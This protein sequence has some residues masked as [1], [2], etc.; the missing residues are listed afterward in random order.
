MV[1]PA[2]FRSVSVPVTSDAARLWRRDGNSKISRSP[3]RL[4]GRESPPRGLRTFGSRMALADL[5]QGLS[6]LQQRRRRQRF[7]DGPDLVVPLFQREAE[8]LER[9]L[10]S[11]GIE[12][13]GHEVDVLRQILAR[14]FG[15][16][17]SGV[18]QPALPP[19][20]MLHDDPA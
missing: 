12:E 17:R 7:D 9:K 13:E 11:E 3:K 14:Q 19:Q 4:A 1:S 16:T 8:D 5:L 2:P 6:D 20:A 10:G 18:P 15:E